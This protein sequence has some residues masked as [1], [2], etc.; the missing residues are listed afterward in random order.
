MYINLVVS[1]SEPYV[2]FL[3]QLQHF[4]SSDRSPLNCV[5]LEKLQGT[6][7]FSTIAHRSSL[8]PDYLSPTWDED[9]QWAVVWTRLREHCKLAN[10][11]LARI[12]EW[13]KALCQEQQTQAKSSHEPSS[14]DIKLKLTTTSRAEKVFKVGLALNT[15]GSRNIPKKFLKAACYGMTCERLLY[16][17]D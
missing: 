14:C 9:T 2:R 5:P 8:Y 11:S 3:V 13:Y 17:G 10:C 12:N 15:R 4:V 16:G 6:N 7:L 1:E